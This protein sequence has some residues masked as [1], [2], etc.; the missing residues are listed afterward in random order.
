MGK[1]L[2]LT[3][4]RFGRLVVIEKVVEKCNKDRHVIWLCLC[5]CGGEVK[6][7]GTDLKIGHTQSCGCLQREMTRERATQHS[8]TGTPLYKVFDNMMLRCYSPISR[9]YKNYGGRGI[10]VCLA[11]REDRGMFFNWAENSGYKVGLQLDRINNNGNYC[12]ENCR[13]VTRKENCNNKRNTI[14]LTL[15]GETFS[16]SRW[17]AEK[18]INYK[19]LK[20]RK[21]DYGWSDEETLTLPVD[22]GSLNKRRKNDASK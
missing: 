14:K 11:W 12:P 5:D 21:C 6:V 15:N 3:G 7:R 8:L 2:E 13:W 16:L 19:T 9:G 22:S 1:K 4:Q 17:S 18:G 10:K 20:S